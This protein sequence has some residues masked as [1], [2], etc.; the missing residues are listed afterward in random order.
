MSLLPQAN[1]EKRQDTYVIVWETEGIKGTPAKQHLEAC[2]QTY[3]LSKKPNML[4]DDSVKN[5]D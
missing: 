2:T 1:R 4:V 5:P 3:V